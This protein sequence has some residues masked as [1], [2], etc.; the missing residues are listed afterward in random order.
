MAGS[1]SVFKATR[2]LMTASQYG[3]HG[4]TSY[5]PYNV[6]VNRFDKQVYMSLPS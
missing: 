5:L 3:V 4:H 1:K 2:P 6:V